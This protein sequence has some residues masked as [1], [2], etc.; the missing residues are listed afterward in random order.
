MDA[1][2]GKNGPLVLFS[3]ALTGCAL[4][5]MA[6][7]GHSSVMFVSLILMGIGM[8]PATVG[9]PI[10]AA[11]FSDSEAYPRVLEW[12]QVSYATGGMILTLLPGM[13]FDR[14]GSYLLAYILFAILAVT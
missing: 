11:D 5:C 2:G 4:C 7:G 8:A 14:T 1:L 13:I 12:M 9:L 10:W 3:A 6:A